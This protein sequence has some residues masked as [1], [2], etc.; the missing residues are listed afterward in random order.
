MHFL[1]N[2][3]LQS[4]MDFI[5][6]TIFFDFYLKPPKKKLSKKEKARLEAEQAELLRIEMEKEK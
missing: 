1:K 6:V 2:G 4:Q 5:V 3:K